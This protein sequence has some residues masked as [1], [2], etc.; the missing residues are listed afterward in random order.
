M[1]KK[2]G[3][4][5]DL[6]ALFIF[7][8]AILIAINFI[9]GPRDKRIRFYNDDALFYSIIAFNTIE[10]EHFSFDKGASRTNGFHWIGFIA[11]Y[12]P[13]KIYQVLG[14]NS[15][16]QNYFFY[17]FFFDIFYLITLSIICSFFI[18][19]FFSHKNFFAFLAIAILSQCLIL[20]IGMEVVWLLAIIIYYGTM[21][22]QNKWDTCAFHWIVGFLIILC[23]IDFIFV[24]PFLYLF[25][26]TIR[27]FYQKI[28]THHFLLI[29]QILFLFLGALCGAGFVFSLNFLAAEDFLSSSLIAKASTSKFNLDDFMQNV[30]QYKIEWIYIL[31]LSFIQITRNHIRSA[32][33]AWFLFSSCLILFVIS[34]QRS[35]GGGNLG[36]WY[37]VVWRGCLLI[38]I[39]LTIDK[40][41]NEKKFYYKH[42]FVAILILGLI[43][44]IPKDTLRIRLNIE[45]EDQKQYWEQLNRLGNK[46]ERST[47]PD[48]LIG[49]NDLP[50]RIT[51]FSNR[52]IVTLDGLANSPYYVRNFLLQQ[53]IDSFIKK[54]VQYILLMMNKKER[55]ELEH[56]KKIDCLSDS[57]KFI[58]M[59]GF[60]FLSNLP[61]SQWQFKESDV[62]WKEKYDKDNLEVWLISVK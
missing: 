32:Q 55:Q 57:N 48:D 56:K 47:K 60:P 15:N 45:K 22:R 26:C 53:K 30:Y 3:N 6:S 59:V 33:A 23:R 16:Y 44:I 38:A 4:F 39:M 18:L 62:L 34:I 9:L 58:A 42:L 11:A 19:P 13:A 61:M 40:A 1:N 5:F 10:G 41:M 2:R 31:V 50:G 21:V 20:G 7:I 14:F 35:M 49:V 36:C 29:K 43:I 28:V 52:K 51:Y 8:I 27:I 46:I 17:H 37:D 24:I 25:G 54:N 12:I